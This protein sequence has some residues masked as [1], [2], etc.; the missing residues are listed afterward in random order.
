MKRM[1]EPR[2]FG[3]WMQVIMRALS[4]QLPLRRLKLYASTDLILTETID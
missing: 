4:Y 2:V 1:S 3:V